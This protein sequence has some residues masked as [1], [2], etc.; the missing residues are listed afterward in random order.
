M[1][2]VRRYNETAEER[3]LRE[4]QYEKNIHNPNNRMIT[5]EDLISILDKTEMDYTKIKSKLKTMNFSEIQTAFIHKSFCV[6]NIKVSDELKEESKSWEIPL[7]K[8]SNERFEFLGDSVIDLIV[9]EYLF[10]R[11]PKEKEGFMTKLRTKLV[12]TSTLAKLSSYLRLTDFIIMSKYVEDLCDGRQNPKLLENCFESLVGVLYK[13]FGFEFCNDFV[14]ALIENVDL[15]DISDMIENDDNFKDQLM[16]YCHRTYEGRNA[17]YKELN[18]EG[19]SN[20]AIF[21]MGVMVPITSDKMV[22]LGMAK[23]PSKKD[24]EQEAA[25]MALNKLMKNDLKELNYIK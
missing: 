10:D 15:I 23:G 25:K 12:R 6:Y 18:V 2:Y 14:L 22:M 21:T 13:N 19:L 16:R 5:R 17:I 9:A 11:Y 1:E 20:Q 7:Q 24:A 8:T 3:A 4:K